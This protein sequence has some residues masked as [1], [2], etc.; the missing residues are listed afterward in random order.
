MSE[1]PSYWSAQKA[2]RVARRRQYRQEAKEESKHYGECA[3]SGCGRWTR[4]T[5]KGVAGICSECLLRLK[6]KLERADAQ[7][8]EGC[9]R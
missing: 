7:P 9:F 2:A 5:S 1:T 8:S 6:E 4:Q 3:S